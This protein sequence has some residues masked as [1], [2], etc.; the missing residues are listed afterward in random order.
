MCGASVH[1]GRSLST[2]GLRAGKPGLSETIHK[3]GVSPANVGKAR[4]RGC[5]LVCAYLGVCSTELISVYF[6]V[7]IHM[8][9]LKDSVTPVNGD[10]QYR[11]TTNAKMDSC[12]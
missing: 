4:S 2:S 1:A 10:E 9:A 12:Q 5:N 7:D 6:L 11:K 8:L 3:G